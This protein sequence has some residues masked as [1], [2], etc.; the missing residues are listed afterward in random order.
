MLRDDDV[1]VCSERVSEGGIYPW[2]PK[3]VGTGTRAHFMS[4][5]SGWVS[6]ELGVFIV[7][8]MD[9]VKAGCTG[10]CRRREA[11]PQSHSPHFHKMT[12][13]TP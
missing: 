1:G 9:G 7:K 10:M 11:N 12:H 13:N 8:L 5:A 3:L 2:F 4:H 6:K